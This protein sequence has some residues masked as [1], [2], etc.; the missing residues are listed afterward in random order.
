MNEASYNTWFNKLM[1]EC[2]EADN[3]EPQAIHRFN[4]AI[5]ADYG[6]PAALVFEHVQARCQKS[7]LEAV[8]VPLSM[9]VSHHPYLGRKA[10]YRG[11][12]TLTKNAGKCMML[13]RRE[14]LGSRAFYLY[15]PIRPD[16][17]EDRHQGCHSFDVYM[18]TQ[19]GVVPAVVYNT[20]YRVS[21]NPQIAAPYN[22]EERFKRYWL[23]S[24]CCTRHGYV[25]E[26]TIRRALKSLVGAGLI[27]EEGVGSRVFWS[28]STNRNPPN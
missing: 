22:E 9:L 1:T 17:L 16:L 24:Y 27:Q 3:A 14:R 15:S 7:G 18:A 20:A 28:T 23:V 19:V 10:L 25:S 12:T 2:D 11:L 6:I 4:P 5:A 21:L 13:L 26:N 8:V